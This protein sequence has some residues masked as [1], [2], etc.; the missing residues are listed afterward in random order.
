MIRFRR[1]T[2]EL[3]GN[4][5]VEQSLNGS[6]ARYRL[7]LWRESRA[8]LAALESELRLYFD[9]A[10]EDARFRLRRGFED[11]LSPFNDPVLDPAANYPALLHWVTLQGYL[12]EI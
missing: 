7:R 12:G 5:L 3:L 8:A 11:T 4:W 9:E 1:L 2:L 10:F 6:H